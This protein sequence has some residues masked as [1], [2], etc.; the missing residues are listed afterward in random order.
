M[1][2]IYRGTRYTSAPATI[3][4]AEIGMTGMYRGVAIHISAP[5]RHSE[6]STQLTYRGVTYSHA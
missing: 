4:T 3:E 1:Q 6:P 5:T 2:L